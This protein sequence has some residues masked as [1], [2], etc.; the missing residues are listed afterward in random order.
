MTFNMR[1]VSVAVLALSMTQVA[2]ADGAHGKIKICRIALPGGDTSAVFL[3]SD[4]TYKAACEGD[5]NC[6]G[7]EIGVTAPGTLKAG[8][9]SCA[10]LDAILLKDDGQPVTAGTALVAEWNTGN[11]ESHINVVSTFK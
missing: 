4:G 1:W 11:L 3:P 2:N 10:T 5:G 6:R 9:S 7:F 8:A